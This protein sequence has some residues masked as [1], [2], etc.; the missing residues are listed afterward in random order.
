M[1]GG[2]W[3]SKPL[4]AS[5]RFDFPFCLIPVL[6]G[7]HVELYRCFPMGVGEFVSHRCVACL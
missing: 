3:Q 6:S 7:G 5:D 4:D 2:L 1:P